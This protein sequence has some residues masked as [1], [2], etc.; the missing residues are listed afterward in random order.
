MQ[1]KKNLGQHF[2]KDQNIVDKLVRHIN[3]SPH[4]EII[5]IGPGDG[6]MT[7]SIINKVK[8]M[9]LIEKDCDLIDN[10]KSS[11][12]DCENSSILNIDILKYNLDSLH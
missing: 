8:K 4:D 6:M 5:E 7:K 2:L 9:I 3:P 12:R 11:F 10:L 1:Y